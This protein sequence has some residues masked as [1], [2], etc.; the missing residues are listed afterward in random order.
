MDINI[1]N[2]GVVAE[3]GSSASFVH[4]ST[5]SLYFTPHLRSDR[6]YSVG[7]SKATEV[8]LWGKKKDAQE[9]LECGFIKYGDRRKDLQVC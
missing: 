9:L 5:V 8:L 2:L 1:E 4:R 6:R 7:F 3:G